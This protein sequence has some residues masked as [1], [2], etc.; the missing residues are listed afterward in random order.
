VKTKQNLVCCVW[1]EISN[2]TFEENWSYLKRIE[3]EMNIYVYLNFNSMP[4]LPAIL[5][6]ILV[7]ISLNKRLSQLS[8]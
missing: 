4:D 6:P 2:F 3:L 8:K 5:K 7:M 1:Q